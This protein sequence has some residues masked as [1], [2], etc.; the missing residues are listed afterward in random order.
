[1]ETTHGTETH[2]S[3]YQVTFRDTGRAHE[4]QPVGVLVDLGH[5]T[6]RMLELE[7]R[8]PASGWPTGSGGRP[9]VQGGTP[10]DPRPKR[11]VNSGSENPSQRHL[12]DV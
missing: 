11:A 5:H 12:Q 9:A 3:E 6:M 8:V 10:L 2:R 4:Q 1:M 7:D